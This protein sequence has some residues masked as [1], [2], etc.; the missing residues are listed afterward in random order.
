MVLSFRSSIGFWIHP[1]LIKYSLTYRVTLRYVLFETYSEP[2]LLLHIQTYIQAYSHPIQT[3]SAILWYFEAWCNLAYSEPCHIQNSDIFRT[4]DILNSIK[5]YS[6]IFWMMF[7][8]CILR[9]PPYSELCHIQNFGLGL[10]HIQNP[11]YISIFNNDGLITLT[12][13]FFMIIFRTFHWN[14]KRHDYN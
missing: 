1:S 10:R 11:V 12:F 2:C 9:T 13:F 7:N 3:Y 4:W 6:G 5:A 14:L 8:T